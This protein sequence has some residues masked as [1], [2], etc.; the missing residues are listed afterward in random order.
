MVMP[1][2]IIKWNSRMPATPKPY[3]LEKADRCRS[4]NDMIRIISIVNTIIT[5]ED[6]RNPHSS[7]TVQKIK[8]VSCSGTKLYFVCVPCKKPFP[9]NPPEPIAIFD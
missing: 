8:S 6:P 1:I 3:I 5:N 4:D 2:L 9:V 7:P